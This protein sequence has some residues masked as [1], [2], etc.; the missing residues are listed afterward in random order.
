M[1]RQGEMLLFVRV[2][3]AESFSATARTMKL[4]PSVVSKLFSRLE[5]LFGADP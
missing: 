1:D 3:D 4:T 5:D 2:V